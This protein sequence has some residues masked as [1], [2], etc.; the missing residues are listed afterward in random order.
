MTRPVDV[1][2]DRL[3]RGQLTEQAAGPSDGWETTLPDGQAVARSRLQAE[4]RPLIALGPDAVPD[5]LPWVHHANAAIRYVAMFALEQITGEHAQ[6]SYFSEDRAQQDAAIATW[7][8]WYERY[9]H[10]RPRS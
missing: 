6:V 3:V 2:F 7:R 4:A 9:E 1:A 8:H 5:L 10:T